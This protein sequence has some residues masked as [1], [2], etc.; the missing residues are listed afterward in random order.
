MCAA[1]SREDRGALGVERPREGWAAW[2]TRQRVTWAARGLPCPPPRGG[3]DARTG[4]LRMN[5][6]GIATRCPRLLPS[7]PYSQAPKGRGPNTRMR[8]F[9]IFHKRST[10]TQAVTPVVTCDHFTFFTIRILPS[11]PSP[12]HQP[13]CS[14]QPLGPICVRDMHAQKEKDALGVHSSPS[15]HAACCCCTLGAAPEG[16]ANRHVEVKL[17][18]VRA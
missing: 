7:P 17:T 1:V 10:H 12:F 9:L 18:C 15:R 8:R 14:L 6:S 11:D 2:R 16:A 4:M 5:G 13:S 3:G